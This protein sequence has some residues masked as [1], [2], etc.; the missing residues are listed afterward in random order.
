MIKKTSAIS[1]I[2]LTL[3][4]SYLS[5]SKLDASDNEIETQE[6]A[7]TSKIDFYKAFRAAMHSY[8][9]NSEDDESLLAFVLEKYPNKAQ[10]QAELDRIFN[11]DNTTIRLVR[12]IDP[13]PPRAESITEN[14]IFSLETSESDH[15]FYAIVDRMGVTPTY[16]YGFN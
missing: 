2:C 9:D 1:F 10:A 5:A 12:I 4:A 15:I 3:C 8:Y 6:N 7:F 14:W 13:M 16:N 11:D